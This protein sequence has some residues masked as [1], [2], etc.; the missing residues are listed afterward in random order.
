SYTPT[1][2]ELWL[3]LHRKSSFQVADFIHFPYLKT[4]K[5]GGEICNMEEHKCDDLSW[6]DLADL[7]ENIILEVKLALE[8]INDKEFYSELGW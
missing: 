1:M 8:H 2:T 6:F 4:N 5:W 3:N 7:P